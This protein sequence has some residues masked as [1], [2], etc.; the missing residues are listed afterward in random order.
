MNWLNALGWL[1]SALLVY[2]IVQTRV[3]RLR[4]LN[5]AA[6]AVLATFNALIGVWPMVAMNLAL[7]GINLFYLIKMARAKSAGRAFE[8]VLT[9][10]DNPY[11]RRMLLRWRVELEAYHPACLT[12]LNQPEVE[13]ALLCQGE[14][15]IGLVAWQRQ[16]GNQAQLL[17]DFVVGAYRDYAPAGY[18]YSSEGPLAEAGIQRVTMPGPVPA[19]ARY[20]HAVGFNQTPGGWSRTVP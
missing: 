13:L 11:V 2:S 4:L 16:A 5:S 1:G 14:A 20:L 7:L 18:V 19:V 12:E 6:S 8:H 9:G 17:V 10:V 15:T 3:L